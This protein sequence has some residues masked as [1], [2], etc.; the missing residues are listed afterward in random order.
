M[1]RVGT[2]ALKWILSWCSFHDLMEIEQVDQLFA[3]LLK[4]DQMF[5]L[6]YQEECNAYLDHKT[7]K[8]LNYR[9]LATKFAHF[10]KAITLPFQKIL[11]C[12]DPNSFRVWEK[13]N[14]GLSLITTNS[15]SS[16]MFYDF[17]SNLQNIDSFI[18]PFRCYQ[19]TFMT[20]NLFFFTNF[21]G[22]T[23]LFDVQQRATI[24]SITKESSCSNVC[25]ISSTWALMTQLKGVHLFDLETQKMNVIAQTEST[26][27]T[28]S[29]WKSKYMLQ[30]ISKTSLYDIRSAEPIQLWHEQ[31][32]GIFNATNV[33][34]CNPSGDVIE[35]YDIRHLKQYQ[36]LPVPQNNFFDMEMRFNGET[37]LVLGTNG[38]TP[39]QKKRNSEWTKKKNISDEKSVSHME[40]TNSYL[41]YNSSTS[42]MCSSFFLNH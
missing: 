23:S 7:E 34:F 1:D 8:R 12:E 4:N 19:C 36:V 21:Y 14:G 20:E 13:S 35:I 26:G 40:I 32:N 31:S 30:E 2:D 24:H 33:A 5:F 22:A 3:Q 15:A 29:S 41:L 38:I 39:F 27:H 9:N 28:L 25:P 37:L 11:E 6:C 18:H 42:F 16:L 17:D 10:G